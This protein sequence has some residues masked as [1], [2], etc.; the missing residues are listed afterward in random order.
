M[1]VRLFLVLSAAMLLGGCRFWYKPVPVANA[2]GEEETVLAGDTVNVHRGARFEVYGPN[3]EAVYDG[4]E[5][6]NR[7]YRAFE[8]YFGV[9]PVRLAFVLEDDSITPL[10]SA[11]LRMFH[12]RGLT[13]VQYTRPRGARTRARYGGIDYGGI[14][15]PVAPTAAR[16]LLAEFARAQLG[17]S[18]AARTD[19]ELL[20][21]FPVWYRSAV[22]RLA[23]D[24]SS[25]TRDLE[26]VREK[27]HLLVPLRDMLP[28]VRPAS[29]DSMI[30]P[31]RSDDAD[32][33]TLTLVAQSGMLAR[34][35]VEREGPGVIGR[36]G[37][38]Y[39]ARRSMADILS[40]LRAP[41]ATVQELDN[42]WRL[43]IDTREH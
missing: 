41:P 28:M 16:R 37:R 29:A 34:Y 30:D 9:T 39:V 20:E 5:Q 23:G 38:G 40:E 13:P 2:V 8:R 42:R 32:E 17:T 3:S 14:L 26:R 18:A 7:A 10:D 6:L 25:A 15:W 43:W 27:R 31:S 35:L 1:R 22:I 12:D 19:V 33:Y 24:A 4:Y 11:T 36:W 21:L